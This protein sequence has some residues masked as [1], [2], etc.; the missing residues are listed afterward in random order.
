MFNRGADVIITGSMI[1]YLDLRFRTKLQKKQKIRPGL[2][3]PGYR[4]ALISC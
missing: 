4:L 1:Y 3:A 2:Q